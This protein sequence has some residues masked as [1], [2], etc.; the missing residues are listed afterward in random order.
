MSITSLLGHP[1]TKIDIYQQR[2]V[3]AKTPKSLV[4]SDFISSLTGEILWAGSGKER[5]YFASA[6]ELN[7]TATHLLYRD[8]SASIHLYTVASAEKQLL[9]KCCSYCQWAPDVDVIVAQSGGTLYVW[10]SALCPGSSV[11]VPIPGAVE[12]ITSVQG[13]VEVISREGCKNYV[14]A[15]D[16]DLIRLGQSLAQGSM[17]EAYSIV[18]SLPEGPKKVM[19]QMMAEVA[20]ACKDLA[21]LALCHEK[22]GKVDD[23]LQIQVRAQ[24]EGWAA[25]DIRLAVALA[26]FSQQWGVAE[27]L[28]LSQGEIGA[29][30]DMYRSLGMLRDAVRVADNAK[31]PSLQQLVKD[32][33]SHSLNEGKFNKAATLLLKQ[34]N[35]QAAMEY[36]LEAG[37]PQQAA[38]DSLL[39]CDR[40][41]A[42]N[43]AVD[44]AATHELGAVAELHGEWGGWLG[45]NGQAE[46]AVHHFLKAGD[47]TAA[48]EAAL[49][50]GQ[51]KSA[52][53]ILD[54]E[55]VLAA[56][57]LYRRVAAGCE[58]SRQLDDAEGYFIKAG[59]PA[60]A[61]HMWLR[62]KQWAGAV[63]VASQHLPDTAAH[64]LFVGH[65]RALEAQK[66]WEDAESAWV[67]AGEP[68]QAVAMHRRNGNLAAMFRAVN[69]H[70]PERLADT[71]AGMAQE[72]EAA[73]DLKGAE[74]HFVEA[75]QWQAAADMYA[76]SGSWED[77]LRVAKAQGG[78][79][80]HD[81]VAMLWASSCSPEE[82]VTILARLD[83]LE[84]AI[85]AALYANNFQHAFDVAAAAVPALLPEVHLRH[86]MFLEDK[87]Q[88]KDAEQ[89]FLLAG[90]PKEAIDMWLHQKNW[91]AARQVCQAHH[92]SGLDSVIEAQNNTFQTRQLPF[93]CMG[94]TKGYKLDSCF[95]RNQ[96]SG[97]H[98][99][100]VSTGDVSAVPEDLTLQ[101]VAQ[102]KARLQP[103][104]VEAVRQP[105]SA[106]V[107][108][109]EALEAEG[110]W[111]KAID[112]Y[113]SV[114]QQHT[115]DQ[116]RQI[117]MWGRAL[118]IAETKKHARLAEVAAKI[119]RRLQRLGQYEQAG[120]L[121]LGAGDAKARAAAGQDES[122]RV[123]VEEAHMCCG[124]A[125]MVLP[126]YAKAG[127]WLL[128]HDVA[129]GLDTAVRDAYL[130]RH[131]TAL[132]HQGQPEQA[133]AVLAH[134][135]GPKAA[136]HYQLYHSIAEALLHKLLGTTTGKKLGDTALSPCHKFLHGLLVD[137][138]ANQIVANQGLR[139][140][141]Q[142]VHYSILHSRSV[143]QGWHGLAAKQATS[144]L[145]FCGLVPADWA[146]ATAGIAWRVAGAANMALTFLNR[147]LDIAEAIEDGL[148]HMQLEQLQGG[149][150]PGK[151]PLPQKQSLSST[152]RAEVREWVIAASLDPTIFQQGNLRSCKACQSDTFE[153]NVVCHRCG[154]ERYPINKTEA[155][156][157]THGGAKFVVCRSDWQQYIQHFNICPVT[158][159]DLRPS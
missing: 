140:A 26:Q 128:V 124:G 36:Y 80:A 91:L 55:D 145:R 11:T 52:A 138:K 62:E 134:Y 37:M 10:Y 112:A 157:L 146:Y 24:A 47:S 15:L 127:H 17:T 8:K 106:L 126:I 3:V 63:H 102:I 108:H 27:R 84:A 92:P 33:I 34:G 137:A 97:K 117:K 70:Q 68:G 154:T 28:L 93:G 142:A 73:G 65:A 94:P 99:T 1:L 74:V 13:K 98:V 81:Q 118:R 50:A 72:L 159:I 69:Q 56:A 104:S 16:M 7:F 39:L 77:A 82:A 45:I 131:A 23:A 121:L 109:A 40:A 32:L 85:D 147:Y 78:T 5:F 41:R 139:D 100:M 129:A 101:E 51:F 116:D 30:V 71:H 130:I 143:R 125:E 132:M 20:L 87:G 76:R 31:H 111:S 14:H 54:K 155:L 57:Q 156:F 158:G 22:M 79:A 38:Q 96:H 141:W 105:K 21:M 107:T 60:E 148:P 75:G 114:T 9:L 18:T 35:V 86:A 46:A 64:E 42:Y 103:E 29:A 43:K 19:W 110:S 4:I 149:N 119:G 153:A 48:V 6:Q 144:L 25:R 133:A 136:E 123:P 113:L 90:Q 120:D 115:H 152:Q 89:E 49:C 88:C 135:G 59:L 12:S 2:F 95:E 44:L 58:A 83:L 61:V 53:A 150:L 66:K 151:L 67:A 122:L